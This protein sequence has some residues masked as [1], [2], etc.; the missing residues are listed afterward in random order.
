ME[1]NKIYLKNMV[2]DRCKMAVRQELDKAGISYDDIELGEVTL[3]S[4]PSAERI[5]KI[6]RIRNRS[7]LRNH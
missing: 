6:S 3:K 4:A 2:C 1:N 7:W 5:Q